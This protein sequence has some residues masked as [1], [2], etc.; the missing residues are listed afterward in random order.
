MEKLKMTKTD[1]SYTI[2]D[3]SGNVIQDERF[4]DYDKL[5]DHMLEVADKWYNGGYDEGDQLKISS[6][7]DTGNLVYSDVATFG[8]T[9]ETA[10]EIP[11]EFDINVGELPGKPKPKGFGK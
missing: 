10:S 6:Y 2:I 1:V 3:K 4:N 7:D 8:E 11:N 9:R 5:A